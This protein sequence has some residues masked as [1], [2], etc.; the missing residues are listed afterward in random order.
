MA[1]FIKNPG[2]DFNMSLILNALRSK[3]KSGANE[4]GSG[5]VVSK[6]SGLISGLGLKKTIYLFSSLALIGLTLGFAVKAFINYK[7]SAKI[8]GSV[9]DLKP[10]IANELKETKKL[11]L[12]DK[13]TENYHG[14]KYKENNELI[15]QALEKEEKSARLF[16][17]AGLNYLKQNEFAKASDYLNEAVKL[18]ERCAECFNNLG[19]LL[20]LNSQGKAAEEALKKSISLD[21]NYADPY[22]NLGV[23]YRKYGDDL[24]AKK[25]LSYYLERKE[26]L[27]DQLAIDT[28]EMMDERVGP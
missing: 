8:E 6:D 14:A 4:K 27:D 9:A 16:N 25:Y 10:M 23:L 2:G 24:R 5:L 13:I 15:K 7:K 28:R 1:R 20:T 26:D 22:F 3:K 18:E 21:E 19:Y 17:L 11:S 12:M